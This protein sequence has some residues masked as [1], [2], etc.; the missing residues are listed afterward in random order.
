M[1]FRFNGNFGNLQILLDF[2]FSEFWRNSYVRSAWE[3]TQ[4]SNNGSCKHE[5]PIKPL[6]DASSSYN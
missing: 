1:S 3:I 4:R 2:K 5:T 6:D